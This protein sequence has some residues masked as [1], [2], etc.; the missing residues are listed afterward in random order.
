MLMRWAQIIIFLSQNHDCVITLKFGKMGK[1]SFF[2]HYEDSELFFFVLFD[3]FLEIFANNLLSK[4]Y[5]TKFFE[6][7]YLN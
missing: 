7:L 6:N 4:S 1:R 3:L 5:S 2:F